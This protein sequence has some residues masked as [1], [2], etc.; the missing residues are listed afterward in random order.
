MWPWFQQEICS[1]FFL[2]PDFQSTSIR[3]IWHLGSGFPQG[4]A[5]DASGPHEEP[6]GLRRRLQG[7]VPTLSPASLS[8]DILES[9]HLDFCCGDLNAYVLLGFYVDTCVDPVWTPV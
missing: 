5:G 8:P 2:E 4:K 7:W 9:N 6:T 3:W 1:I